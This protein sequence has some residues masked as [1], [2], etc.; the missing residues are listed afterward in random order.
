MPRSPMDAVDRV[1]T[2]RGIRVF[3]PDEAQ[4]NQLVRSL[5]AGLVTEVLAEEL[6]SA[7]AWGCTEAGAAA[8]VVSYEAFAPLMATQVSQYLKVIR[9]RPPAGRPPFLIVLSSLGWAN[10]PTHQNTDFTA[11]LL[12]RAAGP[13][14]VVF[15]IGASSAGSRLD[16]LAQRGRDLV[17]VLV[18][19]KQELPDLPDPGGPAVEFTLPSAPGHDGTLIA[20]GDIA[21]AES[22]AAMWIAADHGVRLK[23][24]ALIDLTSLDVTDG[25]AVRAA[26]AGP[27]PA[28]CASWIAA[29]HLAPVYWRVRPEPAVHVG[30]RENWGPTSW[31]TLHANG[32]TRWCLLRALADAGCWLPADC[33]DPSPGRCGPRPTWR[34]GACAAPRV[35]TIG[36]LPGS[37]S[38]I[39]SGR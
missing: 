20:V 33:T 38:G 10:S 35:R 12:A 30:Y 22:V 39:V 3:S 18:C 16:E 29:H 31:E 9:A 34:T 37:G 23:V 25:S 26:C 24:V 11:G 4:S 5:A 6:C 32:L 14:R 36:G 2:R 13:V 8:A 7:W 28:V 1:I 19:S 27:Q 21:V 15:P 17:G